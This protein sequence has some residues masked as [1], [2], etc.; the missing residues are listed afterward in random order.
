MVVSFAAWEFMLEQ[1]RSGDKSDRKDKKKHRDR[2]KSSSSS[3][4]SSKSKK[5]K[6]RK[7]DKKQ[8]K[9]KDKGASG[10]GSGNGKMMGAV[11]QDA[12]GKNGVLREADY[13]SKQR[14]FEVILFKGGEH[15]IQRQGAGKEQH[16]TS[17]L[18]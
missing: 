9:D 12:Y 10:S 2:K 6:D 18:L 13:F 4:R 5:K 11:D 15:R 17:I 8:V 14:E 7:K 1:S 3:S 16:R